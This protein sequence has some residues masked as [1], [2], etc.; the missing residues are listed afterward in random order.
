MGG[1]MATYAVL[2]ATGSCGSA[3]VDMLLRVPDARI[4]A[5]CRDRAKL[6]RLF[7]GIL[8]DKR[9]DVFEGRVDD[10]SLLAACVRGCRAVFLAISTN[11]NVPGC[12]MAQTAAATVLAALRR[13]DEGEAA[14]HR[15]VPRLVLLSS[16]SLDDRL[17]RNDPRPLHWILMRAA[18]HVY[19]DLRAAEHLLRA[20]STWITTVFMKPAGLS[21]DRARGHVL[22]LDEA[23][24]PLSYLDL[25]A[26]MIEAADDVEG[27][28]DERNV[29]VTNAP[30]TGKARFPAGGPFRLLANVL[31]HYFPSSYYFLR[32]LIY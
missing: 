13:P 18:S 12:T 22:S 11:V 25:A 16:A 20:Q 24:G 30:G 7:P 29:G 27:R 26:A 17:S 15:L 28:Y 14:S 2:G 6:A 21:V 1:N 10:V 9:V 32:Y 3:L 8:T 4:H 23:D 5:Y 31:I 19:R